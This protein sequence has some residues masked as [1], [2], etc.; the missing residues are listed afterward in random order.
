MNSEIRKAVVTAIIKTSDRI[1]DL[2]DMLELA[3]C[4][5]TELLEIL[6]S[7]IND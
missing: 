4:S 6:T 2:E 3:S 1:L 7:N 5:D